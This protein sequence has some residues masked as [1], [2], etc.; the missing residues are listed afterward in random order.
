MVS[1]GFRVE[2]EAAERN[3]QIEVGWY[4]EQCRYYVTFE[5]K[6]TRD[7]VVVASLSLNCLRKG[8]GEGT[9]SNFHNNHCSLTTGELIVDN[10]KKKQ[11]QR[12]S[13]S[14]QKQNLSCLPELHR[15]KFAL[16]RKL[17]TQTHFTIL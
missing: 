16:A 14:R 3:N 1:L 2:S 5:A 12:R 7:L 8:F 11:L 4:N 15:N 17:D 13:R 9:Q 6:R 10:P